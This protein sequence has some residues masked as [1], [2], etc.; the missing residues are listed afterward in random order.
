MFLQ[1]VPFREGI[2]QVLNAAQIVRIITDGISRGD[3]RSV[4]PNEGA[5]RRIAA[6][7]GDASPVA[8]GSR[9][10]APSR[11]DIYGVQGLIV[12]Y[13]RILK[14]LPRPSVAMRHTMAAEVR[15]GVSTSR[16]AVRFNKTVLVAQ[17]IIIDDGLRQNF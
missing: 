9:H 14:I 17:G 10:A 8:I 1:E 5:K 16:R 6:A 7:V 2:M 11:N 13:I 12:L 4:L 3:V 15:I